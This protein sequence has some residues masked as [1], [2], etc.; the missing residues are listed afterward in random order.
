MALAA[1]DAPWLAAAAL[2]A[3]S[4]ALGVLALTQRGRARALARE[5][6]LLREQYHEADRQAVSLA[7][8]LKS[9]R[10]SSAEKLAG[11]QAA[12]Q[13]L[14]EAFEALSA[15][16][17]RRNNTSFLELAK[18]SF[19]AHTR[20]SDR[21][22]AER[23]QSIEKLLEPVQ[24]SLARVDAH[25]RE[26]ERQREGAY[27]EI[28][29]Q[30]TLLART[31][32]QL[33]AETANLA[34]ALR[35][36]TVRGQ[37]GELQLRR[38]VE[39]AGMLEHCDFETQAST[40]GEQGLL[41]PDLV[42]RLPGGRSL[43]V[44]AK[45]PLHAYL[46]AADERDEDKR[47]AHLQAHARQ[48]RDHMSRLASKS[49]WTQFQP[50]PEFVVMFLPGEAFFSAALGA[51]P[52]L[53]EHGVH[54]RVIVASPTTLIALLRAVAFGWRQEQLAANA[55][56]ISQLGRELHDRIATLSGHFQDLGRQLRR[57][58]GAYNKVVGSLETRLLSQA[59]RFVELGAAS[60]P[61]SEL[62]PL[63]VQPR[64]LRDA[65][66]G[67]DVLDLDEPDDDELDR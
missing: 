21:A 63:E 7:Q 2:A 11:V 24:Q 34:S 56:R 64:E 28:R 35:A 20:Q 33:Q 47:S 23:Q 51:D 44:D 3:L 9:T 17:L 27:Q 50:A 31:H 46:Q 42:A 43:V 49:Y 40:Q 39:M 1:L 45:T 57:A 54:Q 66:E 26:V 48:V 60:Q 53:I 16:A 25:I 59:R 32:Q 38:V 10:E 5:T 15:D 8:E 67:T 62:E 41:R 22:L 52:T 12:E 14:R 29:T 4:A 37:W 61:L 30:V 13:R 19:E 18:N 6:E 55:Q 36:P 58:V 65:P